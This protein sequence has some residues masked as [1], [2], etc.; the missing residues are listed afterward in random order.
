M[1][2]TIH[3][4]DAPANVLNLSYF[5]SLYPFA[6]QIVTVSYHQ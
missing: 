1:H 2:H 4:L 3:V 5:D 6:M